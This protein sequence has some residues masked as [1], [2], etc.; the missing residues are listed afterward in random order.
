[1]PILGSPQTITGRIARYF[2]TRELL[3]VTVVLLA[4]LLIFF[5]PALF[6]GRYF[7]PSDII[8]IFGPFA[9]GFKA[10][11]SLLSDPVVQFLPWFKQSRELIGSGNMPLWN[12]YSGGGLPLMANMQSQVLW[13][14][15]VLIYLFNLKT[16]LFLYTAGKLFFT[17]FFSYLFLREIKI[18]RAVALVGGIG[19]MFMGFN[20]VWLM[21]PHTNGVFLLPMGFFLAE[22]YFRTFEIQ[23]LLWFS[24]ALALGIFGGHPET[25]FHIV[26][27]ISVY[28]IFCLFIHRRSWK[29][30]AVQI[31]RWVGAGL[32]GFGLSAVLLVPFAEYLKLSQALADRGNQINEYFLYKISAVFHFIPDFFGNPSLRDNYYLA[33]A[34]FNYN[35]TTMAYVGVAL[36]FMTLYTAIWHWRERLVKFFLVLSVVCVAI[37]YNLPVVFDLVVKLPVFHATANHRL[38]LVLGFGIVVM[39]CI[40]IQRLLE[41]APT[42]KKITATTVTTLVIATSLIVYAHFRGPELIQPG[43]NISRMNLWQLI[44]IGFFV[45]DFLLVWLVLF[46][47]TP[48]YRLTL[49]LILVFLE[50]GLHGAVYNTGSSQ[51]NF[52]PQSPTVDYLSK[53][54]PNGYYKTFTAEG[55]LLPP[56][57]GNWYGFNH[58]NDNDAV[59]LKSYTKLKAEIGPLVPGWET[60]AE[61]INFDRLAFL[62]A[63]YLVF[64]KVTG[65]KML[66]TNPGRFQIGLEDGETIILT[67]SALPRSYFIPSIDVIQKLL[68]S[69]D[70]SLIQPADRYQL[71]R[72][73][74]EKIQI[75]TAVNGY[76]I[77][78]ENYYPGWEATVNGKSIKMVSADG[79][80]AIPVQAG[81]IAIETTFRPISFKYGLYISLI[82][83]LVWVTSFAFV[84]RKQSV[85]SNLSAKIVQTA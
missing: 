75:K 17:G 28:I 30:F 33:G 55:I 43:V 76:L 23:W 21:W 82:S 66:A 42:R 9:D 38:S 65:G 47:A 79:L 34:N 69:P 37:I 54:F 62:G 58:V 53:E 14:L 1:M 63:K 2:S 35:E 31:Y 80:R 44:F 12:I 72:N 36:L 25:F 11:N 8:R 68:D 64:P 20:V 51:Q 24:L 56:N 70:Q 41:T 77:L 61:P 85:T 4:A 3:G 60:Y 10:H 73:G 6:T 46:R 39:G 59:G 67:Q 32:L 83:L 29:D 74:D 40:G 57:L 7:A 19:F 48:R 84:L 27:A 45:I 52:Y 5:S 81:D 16:G 78:N 15:S 26:I 50:T 49:L 22:R 71:A 18:N 13:P